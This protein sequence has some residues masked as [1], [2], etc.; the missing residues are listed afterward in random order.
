MLL[1]L[2]QRVA[3]REYLSTRYLVK[4][5]ALTDFEL[6]GTPVSSIMNQGLAMGNLPSNNACYAVMGWYFGHAPNFRHPS[7]ALNV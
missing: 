3:K 7:P 6:L 5:G 4:P 2:V 1:S